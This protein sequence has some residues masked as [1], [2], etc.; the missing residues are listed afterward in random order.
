MAFRHS[1]ILL[2]AIFALSF[3]AAA[4]T[5]ELPR[6]LEHT[7]RERE[8]PSSIAADYNLRLKTFLM[9]NNF[10]DDVKLRPGQVVLIRQLDYD[11][12]Q[13]KEKGFVPKVSDDDEPIATK[14][15]ETTVKSR[16][17]SV[18]KTETTTTTTTTDKPAHTTPAV[19]N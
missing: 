9:L 10:P 17:K 1:V 14:K 4:Q 19:G 18:T 5:R 3:S 13:V 6:Y 15:P 12:K 2:F 16:S 7:V 8:T 11:E